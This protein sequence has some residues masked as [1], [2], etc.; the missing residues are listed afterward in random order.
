V[1]SPIFPWQRT[2]GGGVVGKRKVPVHN[3]VTSFSSKSELA[4]NLSATG[5]AVTFIGSVTND[6]RRGRNPACGR[7]RHSAP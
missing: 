6:V 4:L 5:R 2:Q 1:T 7:A 3:L